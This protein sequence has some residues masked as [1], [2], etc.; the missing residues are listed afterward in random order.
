MHTVA[1]EEEKK[2]RL[3]AEN[4]LIKI[5][6]E[7]YIKDKLKTW[8]RRNWIEL[9]IGVSTFVVGVLWMMSKSE[10][11][12]NKAM[13]LFV[14]LNKNLVFSSLLWLAGLIFSIVTLKSLVDKYRNHSNIK[15]FLDN[16]EKFDI[17]EEYKDKK[18]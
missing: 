6:R 16:L 4:D 9:I 3:K 2:K 14:E 11:D 15:A 10:W 8:R 12:M 13:S 18:E 7:K 1:L 5:K 17:P